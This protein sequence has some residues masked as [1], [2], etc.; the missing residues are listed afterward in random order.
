MES[1]KL[2]EAEAA[3]GEFIGRFPQSD[4]ADNAQYWMGECLYGQKSFKE[5]RDA[6][7]AVSDHF[8]FGN[9]VP[10]A[11]YKQALC[12]RELGDAAAAAE[13]LKRLTEFFPDSEAAAKARAA[14]P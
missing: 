1:G 11:L 2:D 14:K 3:F 10:D 9:K 6:F 7:K 4:L 13:T 5:A 12:E 8:P